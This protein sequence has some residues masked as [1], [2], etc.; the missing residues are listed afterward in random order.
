MKHVYLIQ[1][2]SYPN[3]KYVGVTTDL[4]ARLEAHNQGKSKHTTKYRPWKLVTAVSFADEQ[5]AHAFE[6]YLKSGSG[7]AFA[8]KRLW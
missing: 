8:N 3:Q 5:K 6:H 4:G 1:S 7:R 2:N